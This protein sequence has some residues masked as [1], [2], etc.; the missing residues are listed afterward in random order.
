METSK[1]MMT[2]TSP[3][4]GEPKCLGGAPLDAARAR[5]TATSHRLCSISMINSKEIAERLANRGVARSQVHNAVYRLSKK[6]AS[7]RQRFAE[8]GAYTVREL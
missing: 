2:E 8:R 1:A 4:D 6:K 3:S 5:F 7:C